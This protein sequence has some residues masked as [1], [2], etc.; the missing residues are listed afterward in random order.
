MD[1]PLLDLQDVPVGGRAF[2][3]TTSDGTRVR[4]AIWEGGDSGTVLLF[5]GR[6]EYI[7]KYG[8]VV[9]RLMSRG[10]N[11]V[12]IDWRGQGLSDRTD[13]R[14]DRGYVE[15]FS[16]YQDDLASVLAIPEVAALSGPRYLFSHS[17]GGCIAMRTLIEGLDI[18]AAVFSAP[19]WGLQGPAVARHVLGAVS[20]IGRPI[21]LHKALVPGTKPTYYVQRAEFEGNEL[22]SDPDHYAF[23]RAQLADNPELGLGGPTIQWAAHA[24]REMAALRA[25]PAP[26]TRMLVFLGTN[27]AVVDPT[28]VTSFIP[29][30]PNAEL[31]MM[32]GGKHECWMETPALQDEIWDATDKFLASI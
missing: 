2:F 26:I 18:K 28:A 9:T 20:A 19:M 23:F 30:L 5:P 27:E 13:G 31:L 3:S 16:D 17:M 14:T 29:H 4:S 10:L 22:T 6:T 8:R 15:C 25:D 12:V 11:V 1:A 7:E 21:G 32:E 24:I